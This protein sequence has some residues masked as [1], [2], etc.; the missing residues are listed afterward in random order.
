MNPPELAFAFA[1]GCDDRFSAGLIA[2]VEEFA[3]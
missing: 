3:V 1:S 2:V